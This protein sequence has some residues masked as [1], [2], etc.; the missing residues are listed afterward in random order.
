MQRVRH[1]SLFLFV[2][3][4]AACGDGTNE[5]PPDFQAAPVQAAV[6]S[7]LSPVEDNPAMRFLSV[8][9]DELAVPGAAYP[10]FAAP[11]ARAACTTFEDVLGRTLVFNLSTD[12]YEIDLSR[13]GA[14]ANGVRFITYEVDLLFVAEPLVETGVLDLTNEA[15]DGGCRLRTRIAINDQVQL[16][17][18]SNSSGNLIVSTLVHE[19]EGTIATAGSPVTMDIE[20]TASETAGVTG[21]YLLARNGIQA[22]FTLDFDFTTF[23]ATTT[24]T[25]TFSGPT[26]VI[27]TTGN[28]SAISGDITSG[29]QLVARIGGTSD[30]P[31]F[32]DSQGIP[33]SGS[34]LTVFRAL[35]TRAERMVELVDDAL[36]PSYWVYGLGII[37]G[38]GS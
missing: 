9:G 19:A 10:V 36:M 37:F 14:P 34:A 15:T 13:G 24:L 22:R 5:P 17:Y 28:P 29:G 25:V 21:N 3:L 38:T 11:S 26:F 18:L 2:A 7:V 32:E 12:A 8:M 35:F 4:G 33:F 20:Q 23:I 27:T 6:D 16:E 1:A 30:N 31:T